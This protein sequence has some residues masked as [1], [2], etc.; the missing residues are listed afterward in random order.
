MAWHLTL[1]VWVAGHMADARAACKLVLDT[2]DLDPLAQARAL[3]AGGQAAFWQ[4]DIGEAVPMLVQGRQMFHELGD[5]LGYGQS[6]VLLGLVAWEF[7]GLEASQRMF[8]EAIEIFEGLGKDAWV[9]LTLTGYC[10]IFMLSDRYEGMSDKFE[11]SVELATSIGADLTLGMSYGNLGMLRLWEGKAEEGLA[12]Q[13]KGIKPL[14][15]A[16]HAAAVSYTMLNA[17]ECLAALGRSEDAAALVGLS[18]G[19]LDQLEVLPISLMDA[20]RARVEEGLRQEMGT[21]AFDAAIA[22]A[23]ELSVEDGLRLMEANIPASA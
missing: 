15:A 21:A 4:G 9:S 8:D 19:L 5:K 20:R 14:A 11:R 22:R 2:P 13:L 16:D 23:S 18:K 10:W 3:V 6:L 1:F 7:E 17:S 12:Y